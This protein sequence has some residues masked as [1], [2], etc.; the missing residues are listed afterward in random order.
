[1]G[2]PA[3]YSTGT[4]TG[5]SLGGA[6]PESV[7][8]SQPKHSTR[9]RHQTVRHV[10]RMTFYAQIVETG[11]DACRL[12]AQLGGRRGL[13]PPRRLGLRSALPG[14]GCGRRRQGVPADVGEA[15]PRVRSSRPQQVPGAHPGSQQ[16]TGTPS[17]SMSPDVGSLRSGTLGAGPVLECGFGDGQAPPLLDELAASDPAVRWPHGRMARYRYIAAVNA[18]SLELQ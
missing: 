10:D 7:K 2:P 12:R 4:P 16:R 13:D 11:I 8:L 5:R 6:E 17:R 9:L 1:M 18:K 3:A 14:S 15:H